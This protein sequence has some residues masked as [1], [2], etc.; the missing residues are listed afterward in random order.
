M[1]KTRLGGVL[2][3]GAILLSGTGFAAATRADASIATRTIIRVVVAENFW[4]SIAKQEAGTRAQVTSIIVNPNA[5][6]HA[7]EPTVSDARLLANSQYFIMNGAGYDPWGPK[8]LAANP[9]KGRR[10]L[11]VADLN[12]KKEGD[13]P[14]MW[15][16][17]T[18]VSR[19]ADRIT[20]DLTALD[21]ADAAYFA[22]QHSYFVNVALRPYH[23]EISHIASRYHGVPVAAT[24][25]IF[26]Y[27]AQALHL[28]LITPYGFMKALSEGTEPTAQDKATFDRQVTQKEIKV[29]VF[30][31]QNSTP[32]TKA[33]EQKAKAEHIPVVPITETLQPATASFQTWQGAQ[34][35]ALEQALAHAT[36]H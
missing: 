19:V 36:G 14:H 12:G 21:P 15:Y 34:L 13:N 26:Q 10:V 17:P 23:Q 35:K 3:L 20:S 11:N 9:V 22:R 24:E 32:D 27:L 5:D 16:S 6:P 2:L 30:N 1:G 31:S 29:L 18:Y 28:N 8:L 25:S 33:L 7:Y 4:G